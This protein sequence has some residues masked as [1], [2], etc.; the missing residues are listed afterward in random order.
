MDIWLLTER[1]DFEAE[2]LKT[3]IRRTFERRETP[4]PSALPESLSEDFFGN[5]QK[6]TQWNAFLRKLGDAPR[7]DSL[8]VAT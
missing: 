1:F 5:P 2:L 7:P 6:V 4:L 8:G 3:A